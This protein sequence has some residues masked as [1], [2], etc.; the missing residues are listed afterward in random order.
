MKTFLSLTRSRLIKSFSSLLIAVVWTSSFAQ[1]PRFGVLLPAEKQLQSAVRAAASQGK[2][3]PLEEPEIELTIP[4]ASPAVE[5]EPSELEKNVAESL[6]SISLEEKI[7]KQVLQEELEQFG[8]EIFSQAPTTFAPVEGIPVPPGYVIGPGDTFILQIYGATDVEYRLVVT[9]EGKLLIPEVGD[10]QVAGL[11]FDEAKLTLTKQISKLRIGVKTVVTLAELHTIQIMMVG[12]VVRPGAY[13][14]SGLSSLLNTLI[15]TGG[16]KRSGTLRNI[17]VR[18]QNKTITTMDIYQV[19]LQGVD[20][21]NIFLRHGDVVFVPP[22]GRTIGVAGEVQRP[23]IYE[24]KDETSV[25]DV[26]ALAGGLLPTSAGDKSHVE[27]ITSNGLRTL[28][29]ADLSAGGGNIT[30]KN[31]DLIRVFPVLD[32]M[33]DVVLLSGHVLVPGGFQWQQGMRVSDLISSP[34]ILRQSAEYEM[35]LVQREVSSTKRLEA[36]YFNLGSVLTSPGGKGDIELLSRD[37][38]IIFD[39]NSPRKNQVADLV[40]KLKAQA[41]AFEPPNVFELKGYLRHPGEY[42]LERG[43]RLLDALGVSGGVLAGTDTRYTLLVRKDQKTRQIEFIQLNLAEARTNPKGDHN[44]IIKPEDRVYVFDVDIDRAELIKSDIEVVKQQT[45]YG[46]LSPVVKVSGKV[47]KPGT[48]PLVPG[49]RVS[50]LVDAAGGM[51]E[52]AFGLSASLSRH[53]LVDGEFTAND[54]IDVK[55]TGLGGHGYDAA[56]ILHPYDHLVL[57]EK[58]EWISKP[59]LVKIEGEVIYPGEYQ[60][61]KRETLCSLVQRA[62]GFTEDAYLFGSVFLRESVRQREQQAMDKLYDEMDDLLVEVQ[63]SPGYKKDEKLPVNQGAVDIHRVLK[64]LQRDK[65]AGRLV[66]DLESAVNQCDEKVDIMLEDGDRLI[67]PKYKDEVSVV[68]QVYFPSSHLYRSDRA[69]LDYI[70]LSGGTKELAMREHAYVVQANGEV[71]TVRSSD[72]TWGWLGSPANVKVTPGST[73]YVPL[74]VD[75]I[76]AR[77]FSESWIELIYKL[78]ISAA[79]INYILD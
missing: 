61:G 64:Q 1:D 57:R 60:V 12:E 40:R 10:I 42:P 79:S 73:I 50:D 34:G 76:N 75:R 4:V 71:M 68:G 9:R 66:V 11:T 22:I 15:T 37:Q 65:A 63:L 54:H 5:E 2:D 59:K 28:V 72:S 26:L 32:K 29:A 36:H 38:V 6:E 70:N 43:M 24:L 39:T 30:V 62:G 21:S 3:E 69:A 78:A 49:M 17:Q 44:P 48:Y 8:Y 56:M 27:R 25:D 45:R 20:Q 16:I 23:A 46:S 47:V 41:T 31:G 18:R 7:Q 58:P 77:E 55:L 13:T 14:I 53:Q 74:S 35:A 67:V 52:D 19:L 33:D 51:K